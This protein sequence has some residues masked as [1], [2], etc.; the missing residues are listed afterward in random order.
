MLT[1]CFSAVAELLVI[2]CDH[3]WSCFQ[4]GK[5]PGVDVSVTETSVQLWSGVD[6]PV[7]LVLL[8]DVISEVKQADRQALFQQLFTQ[9]LAPNGIVIIITESYGPAS[10]LMLIMEH[11][12]VPFE[13]SYEEVEKE[14]LAAGFTL[15]HLQDINGPV[16]YSNPGEDLVK[17]FQ[18]LAHNE[19]SEEE[20]RAAVNDV[21]G[22]N[23]QMDLSTKMGIFKK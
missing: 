18:L 12:G 17:Y 3:Y 15:L 8:F 16:D 6:K 14:M 5:L 13:V 2:L 4:D 22:P 20:V 19:I 10:G 7:D 21:A 11:L 1:R 9:Q 23:T